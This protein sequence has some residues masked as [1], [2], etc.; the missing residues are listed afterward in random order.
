MLSGGIIMFSGVSGW[1]SLGAHGW[2]SGL[3]ARR[4]R[5][6]RLRASERVGEV[7][8]VVV[9]V[10]FFLFLYENFLRGVPFFTSAFGPSEQLL[11]FGPLLSGV[12]ISLLRA[13][14]G[15]RN[16]LRPLDVLQ[17]I[18]WA[19]AA[20][21]LLSVFPFDFTHFPEMFPAS[22]RFAISWVSNDLYAF[23]LLLAGIGSIA[24][25]AYT[26]VL[27]SL[28]RGSLSAQETDVAGFRATA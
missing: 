28:V 20:F 1:G 26:A 14:H 9:S 4:A 25:A 19:V 11:F 5:K 23:L 3:V 18:F 21:W 2:S 16:A 13:I 17:A 7:I 8:G 12:L 15:R 6:D 24:N 27:Y 10:F 22:I